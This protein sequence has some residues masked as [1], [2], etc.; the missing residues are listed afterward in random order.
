MEPSNSVIAVYPDHN[1]VQQAINAGTLVPVRK[2]NERLY[3]SR[4]WRSYT[5]TTVYL[6]KHVSRDRKLSSGRQ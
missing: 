1:A 6:L 3:T 4:V 5:E 2:F